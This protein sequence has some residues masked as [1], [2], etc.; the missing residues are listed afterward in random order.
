[1]NDFVVG[2]S[3]RGNKYIAVHYHQ[4]TAQRNSDKT[5]WCIDATE[6]Y[7]LFC[8]ADNMTHRWESNGDLFGFKDGAKVVLS[9]KEEDE[10]CSAKLCQFKGCDKTKEWHGF[11]VLQPS[12]KSA[13][14]IYW[15]E[16]QLISSAIAKKILKRKKF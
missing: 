9:L 12:I 5:R 14:V 6:Q 13:L 7:D 3:E 16:K 8:V 1:M 4:P 15:K 10:D 2:E 11:P